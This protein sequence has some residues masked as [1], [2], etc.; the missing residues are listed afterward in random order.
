MPK[1]VGP[2]IPRWQ[3]GEQLGRL[4]KAAGIEESEVAEK[5]ACSESK[6]KK[7]EAGYVGMNRAELLVMLDMFGVDDPRDREAMI[8][9]Q[10]RGKQRGWWAQFGM[11]PPQFATFLS[12][13]SSA[14]TIR[15][16]EP[17]MVHGLLQTEDYTRAIARSY[18]PSVSAEEIERQV[19]IR[20]GRQAQVAADPPETWI[21]LD[22]AVLH[23]VVGGPGVMKEQLRHILDTCAAAEWLTLQVLPFSHGSHPGELGAFTLFDFEEDVHSPVV[24]VEGQAGGLYLERE[25]DLRRCNLAY[26]HLTAAALSPPE[27]IKLIAAV[28]R[29]L[30]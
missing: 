29:T 14:T 16:F 24:Y 28:A 19:K 26:K 17:L 10:K 3:L 2:T 6:I 23:R 18:V 22:E 7:I 8:E 11:V 27:S 20:L 4:R 15:I 12:L 9:L 1:V 25:S 30:D 21:V 13:E 5:L